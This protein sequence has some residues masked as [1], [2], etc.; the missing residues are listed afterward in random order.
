MPGGRGVNLTDGHALVGLH[1]HL[2]AALDLVLPSVEGDLPGA[3]LRRTRTTSARVPRA[4]GSPPRDRY[5][6]PPRQDPARTGRSRGAKDRWARGG[7]PPAP[8]P[9]PAPKGPRPWAAGSAAPWSRST[10]LLA[11]EDIPVVFI[12]E[13]PA[14]LGL[15]EPGRG[16]LQGAP[17]AAPPLRGPVAWARA[18]RILPVLPP[19]AAA[20]DRVGGPVPLFLAS[21]WPR[22]VD[23][24]LLALLSF[25]CPSAPLR[26]FRARVFD[27]AVARR[28]RRCAPSAG[29]F[30]SLGRALGSRR[31]A[32][33]PPPP[34]SWFLALA[35]AGRGLGGGACVQPRN[36][37][38]LA[39]YASVMGDL[40][41]ACRGPGSPSPARRSRCPVRRPGPRL[42]LSAAG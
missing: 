2:I 29:F 10:W 39:V 16:P 40:P 27:P 35:S 38:N 1:H 21:P 4:R 32:P 34:S 26:V 37:G 22:G 12:G 42:R 41:G 5:V 7:R 23:L 31:L 18:S 28:R 6:R 24:R 20:A 36:G 25:E 8:G 17:V 15:W 13:A 14:P 11:L 9:G 33:A 3:V 19:A 30:S